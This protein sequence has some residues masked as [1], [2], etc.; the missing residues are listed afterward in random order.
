MGKPVEI[1]EA[2]LT[3]F[4]ELVARQKTLL[5]DQV[6][7]L[8]KIQENDVEKFWY[9]QIAGLS[10]L[11]TTEQIWFATT[12]F[13]ASMP[14]QANS[15]GVDVERAK[16]LHEASIANL[17]K[18]IDD[19]EKLLTE[20]PPPDYLIGTVREVMKFAEGNIGSNK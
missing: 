18:A 10:L 11:T 15:L 4:H 14:G 3:Q 9:S 13:I 1:D 8:R 5:E 17:K 12:N 16:K 2:D 6:E 7:R 20:N 19:V